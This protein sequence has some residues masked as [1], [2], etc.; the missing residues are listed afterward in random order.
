MNNKHLATGLLS[1]AILV[2]LSTFLP[3]G[4]STTW[5]AAGTGPDQALALPSDWQSLESGERLWYAFY[6]DGSDAPIHVRLQTSPGGGADFEVWTPDNVHRW[7]DGAEVEPIGRGSPDPH[8]DDTLVWSGSF[9]VPGTYYV[10]VEHSEVKPSTTYY[11]L[12]ISGN[13][14]ALS[15]PTSVSKPASQ[16][17]AQ[18]K[19]AALATPTGRLAFQTTWGGPFYTINVDGSNLQRITD[20]IDAA[21]SR[22]GQRIAFTRWREPRGVYVIDVD[23]TSG[24]P[25]GERRVFDWTQTRWP[26]W[27]PDDAQ[28][29]FSRAT[30]RGRQDAVEYCFFGFCFSFPAHPLIK[31][32]TPVSNF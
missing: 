1:F 11:F 13:G 24:A 19:A 14:V 20:G 5:A 29:L 21:W 12:E 7:R 10:V 16:P 22:D 30:G 15:A 9:V 25:G 31:G 17:T 18:A 4:M 8:A 23:V 3:G 28:I 27:S 2:L 32:L 26:S 6:Y